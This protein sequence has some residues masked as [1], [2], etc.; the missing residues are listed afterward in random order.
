MKMKMFHNRMIAALILLAILSSVCLGGCAT[1]KKPAWMTDPELLRSPI[2]AMLD[3][4]GKGDYSAASD[5]MQGQ[6]DLGFFCPDNTLGKVLWDAFTGSISYELLGE[7]YA[8]E[9]GA[10]HKI[11]FTCL[12]LSPINE[13]LPERTCELLKAKMAA[14][15]DISEVYDENNAYR[16]ELIDA[17]MLEAANTLL[18]ERTDTITVELEVKLVCEGGQWKIIPDENL[19][20]TITGGLR[21]D[22]NGSFAACIAD[23]QEMVKDQ[24]AQVEKIFWLNDADVIAPKPNPA[25]YGSTTDPSTLQWLLDEAAVLLDG[26]ETLFTT[27]TEIMPGSEVVYYLDDTILSITW[28]Q[29]IGGVA[30]AMSEVKIAHPSQFRRYLVDNTYGV[31]EREYGS[32]LAAEV[33]AVTASNADY[34]IRRPYGIVVYQGEVHRV[35]KRLDVCFIDDKGDLILVHQGEITDEETAKQFVADNHIRFSLAFGPI[36]VEDGKNVT[37][38]HYGVGE[39]N[40][41]F[42]RSALGMLGELHYLVATNGK[43][44]QCDNMLRMTTL[45]DRMI[46]FGCSKAYALDGGQTS[47]IVTNNRVMSFLTFSYQRKVSDIIY[48]ATAIPDGSH[49]E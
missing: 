33:N 13:A 15:G 25:C 28:Q 45:A 34:Y 42:P 5:W 16:Q 43:T 36:I 47:L 40:G 27:E 29:Y 48:F 38:P 49:S 21:K 10:A 8:L 46:A 14:G 39:I 11:R 30:M 44:P 20:E 3:S 24:T 18:A 9:D 19:L 23:C 26:Q 32:D 12:D 1:A 17:L 2:R 6:P 4:V 41:Y 7:G 31:T 37:P 35:N 22:G